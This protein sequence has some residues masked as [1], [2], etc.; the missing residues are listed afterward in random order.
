MAERFDGCFKQFGWDHVICVLVSNVELSNRSIHQ[1]N[2]FHEA[3]R[4]TLRRDEWFKIIVASTNW[5][6][7]L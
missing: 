2:H 3:V 7:F 4:V 5:I 1:M 6:L